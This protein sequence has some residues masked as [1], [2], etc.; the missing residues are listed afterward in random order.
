MEREEMRVLLRVMTREIKNETGKYKAIQWQNFLTTIQQTHGNKDKM[1][2]SYLSR[3]YRT[4]ALPFYK[5]LSGNKALSEQNEI[6]EELHKYYSEQFKEPV[7]DMS[8]PHEVE[9]V[10]ECSEILQILS[11][12]KEQMERTNS[13]EIRRIIQALK[14]KKSAGFDQISNFIIKKL[15]MSYIECLVVC[16]NQWLKECR[17]PEEWKLARIITLNKIKAGVP[18]CEQTRPISLLATHSKLFE[19]LVL[20]RVRYWVETNH[21]IPV[22]QSGFRPRCLLPTRVLS[23]FQE[24]KNS[25][26]ANI[27]TLAIYVDYQKAYDQV[28]HAALITKLWWLRFPLDMLKMLASWLKDRKAYVVF[29]DKSSEVFHINIGLPQGSSLSPYLFIV[30]HC[31]LMNSIGAHSGHLFAVDLC[32]IIRPPLTVKLTPM[33][34]YLEREGTKICD[35]IFGY[36]KKWKQ[37]INISK[38]VA[39]LFYTQ[40]KKPRVKIEMNGQRIEL[41]N[42][43]KY[44][45]FTWTSTLSL[46]PTINRCIGNIQKSLAKLRWLRTGRSMSTQALRQCFFAYTFPHFAW[47]FPFFPLLPESQQQTLHQ[48]FRVGL[49]LVHRCPFVSARNIYSLTNEKSLDSYVKQYIQKRLKNIHSTDLR[50]LAFL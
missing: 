18:K 12:S 26:V 30:F 27:P 48:K 16:F 47:L 49:R 17:Y 15:P 28:W 19:K 41:V 42:E 20:N 43:F 9:V 14:P 22:E 37:P 21:I 25:M 3:I 6:T 39:Q 24:V 31:D 45:G 5:L 38:T 7:V 34:E 46:K 33:I 4:R 13:F 44:L 29:G 35:Q 2:W 40:I 10:N 23:I 11:N 1:F 36:S 50:S 8:D 32:V